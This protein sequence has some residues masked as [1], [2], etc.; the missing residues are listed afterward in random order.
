MAPVSIRIIRAISAG[1]G[2][3]AVEDK[4]ALR[5]LTE[6]CFDFFVGIKIRD[7]SAVDRG[8]RQISR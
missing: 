4:E 1:L 6:L 7:V 2:R 5:F 3:G 8:Y